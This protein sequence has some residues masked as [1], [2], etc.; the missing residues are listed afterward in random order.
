MDNID[1]MRLMIMSIQSILSI[2]SIIIQGYLRG[3]RAQSI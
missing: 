1:I 2:P 3:M